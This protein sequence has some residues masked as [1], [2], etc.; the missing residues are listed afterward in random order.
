M[1]CLQVASPLSGWHGVSRESAAAFA[2]RSAVRYTQQRNAIRAARGAMSAV[3][4]AERTREG[5]TAKTEVSELIANGSGI[6]GRPD[7]YRAG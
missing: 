2:E 5:E 6:G 7:A 3:V 4:K 1:H